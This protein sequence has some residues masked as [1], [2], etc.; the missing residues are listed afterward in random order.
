MHGVDIGGIAG[1]KSATIT[2][3][4]ITVTTAGRSA[5]AI[6]DVP[7]YSIY[8]ITNNTLTNPSGTG[9][10]IGSVHLPGMDL[11]L[12]DNIF[13]GSKWGAILN[14]VKG[15]FT[16]SLTNSFAGVGHSGGTP[17]TISGVDLT[18]DGFAFGF[19]TLEGGV[20]VAVTDRLLNCCARV[21]STAIT[22]SNT[23]VTGFGTGINADVSNANSIVDLTLDNVTTCDNNRGIGIKAKDVQ[24]LGGNVGG[25]TVDG[26]NVGSG[27]A[28]VLIDGVN[29]FGNAVDI[30]GAGLGAVTELGST[31]DPF[32]CPVPGGP[33]NAPPTV[34]TTPPASGTFTVDSKSGPVAKGGIGLFNTGLTL[35]GNTVSITA[36]GTWHCNNPVCQTGPNGTG[37]LADANFL[38][39]GLS[40]FSLIARVGSGPW[41]FVGAGPTPISGSGALV[42]AMN[43]NNPWSDNQGSMSV[44]VIPAAVAD[45]GPGDVTQDGTYDDPDSGQDVAISASV[46]SVSK[47]GVNTGDWSWSNTAP[48]G[49]DDYEVIITAD[50]GAGETATTKFHVYVNNVAP[51]ASAANDGPV[52][53]NT[54]ATVTVTATDPAGAADPLKYEFDFDNDLLY[55]VGPQAGNSAQNTY[56]TVGFKTVNVRVTDGDGGSTTASTVVEVID[57]TPPVVTAP[58]PLTVECTSSSGISHSDSEIQAWLA[59]ASA[60]DDV[61][62]PGLSVT[63]DA[64]GDCALGETTVTFTATDAAGNPG[65]AQ[66]TI[67]VVDNTAPTPT[68]DLVPIPGKVEEDE[69]WFNAVFSCSDVCDDSPSAVGKMVTPSVAGLDVKFKKNKRVRVVFDFEDG[70]VKIWGPDAQSRQDTW[71]QLLNGGLLI[72][73]GQRVH[74]EVDDDG[75]EATFQFDKRGNLKIEAPL[76]MMSLMVTCTDASGNDSVASAAPGFVA[77]EEDEDSEDEDSGDEDSDD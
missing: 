25:S 30:Q 36:S 17:L 66:S 20:G 48:D 19:A 10:N 5:L 46:G 22:I 69:G 35:T 13:D 58:A 63:N 74:F 27:S 39:P 73:S 2:G 77:E 52:A 61:D 4:T 57:I 14:N 71:A 64:S 16:L 40:V 28:N 7:Q 65:S 54:I 26:I 45:E 51:T 37:A 72:D 68:A 55:E 75:E 60:S 34:D 9:L 31:F 11:T 41:Q 3:N 67:T 15:P 24:I 29:F 62:G 6:H 70:E 50:D 47:T 23:S 33:A 1:V 18:V 42:F 56:T 12:E 8:S 38:G 21:P 59:S 44:E 43:D 53:A 32:N 76:S 49:P